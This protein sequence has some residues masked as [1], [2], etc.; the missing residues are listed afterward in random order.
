MA[1]D[2]HILPAYHFFAKIEEG[3]PDAEKCPV[4]DMWFT[5]MS[6]RDDIEQHIDRCV[7][8]KAEEAKKMVAA[9]Y[10]QTSQG[11]VLK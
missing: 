11:W 2:G 1:Y 9:G 10:K 7:A 8:A 4:C 6:L 3:I 5:E